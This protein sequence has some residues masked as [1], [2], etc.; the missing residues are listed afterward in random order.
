MLIRILIIII[1]IVQYLAASSMK[2]KIHS[3]NVVKEI[4]IS[5]Q[6]FGIIF[7]NFLKNRLQ[8]SKIAHLILKNDINN[9]KSVEILIKNVH[10]S[11]YQRFWVG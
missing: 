5:N 6:M 9:A 1:L 8:N 11:K 10:Q 4:S 2:S 3:K 7:E